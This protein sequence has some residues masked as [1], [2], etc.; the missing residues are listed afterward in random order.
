LFQLGAGLSLLDNL[1]TLVAFH[2]F[3]HERQ[4][5]AAPTALI[6][7]QA[8]LW[9]A[10]LM[11]EPPANGPPAAAITV[12]YSGPD[13]ATQLAVAGTMAPPATGNRIH[14]GYATLLAPTAQAGAPLW[15]SLPLL[16]AEVSS[17]LP[18][19]TEPSLVDRW[20]AWAGVGLA[21]LLVVLALVL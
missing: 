3:A 16:L 4:D 1:P 18:S 19:R 5:V 10:A 17:A 6:G 2:A 11:V 8:A 7:G 9:L 20:L 12:I 21:L 15:A 14:A 13:L